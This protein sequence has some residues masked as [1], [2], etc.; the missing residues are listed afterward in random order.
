MILNKAVELGLESN[1][2][3]LV[4]SKRTTAKLH[5]PFDNLKEVLKEIKEYN[6]NLYLCC[7]MT[8]GCLLRPHREIR[9]LTWNDFSDD[10]KFIN[11][12]GEDNKSGRNR[13]VPVPKYIRVKLIRDDSFDNIFTGSTTPP[14]PH[15]FCTLW[16]RF[17]SISKHLKVGQT[18]YS[19]RHTG[20]I[21]IFKRTG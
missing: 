3:R 2:I 9:Q 10:L 7:L 6:F 5:K 17:K 12:S 16:G 11:L 8:Y 21:E 14:N 19:F 20:A 4:R 1:P 18:L 13:I 15:Y